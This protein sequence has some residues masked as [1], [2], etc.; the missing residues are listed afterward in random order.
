MRH[1]TTF[2]L[3]S[4]FII[5]MF[6]TQPLKAQSGGQFDRDI[7]IAE[8]I[9]EELFGEE[10]SARPFVSRSV[11]DVSG[12]YI[13]GYGIH[14]T[15]GSGSSAAFVGIVRPG[16]ININVN[17]ESDS[18][19]ESGSNQAKKREV[20]E[21]RFL[22]YLK[23]YAPLFDELPDDEV[24]RLTY[25]R[26]SNV[27]A[28][29]TIRAGESASRTDRVN[30]TAWATAEDIRAYDTNSISVREFESRVEIVDLSD[31]ET[32]RDQTVFASILQTSLEDVSDTLRIRRSP[33]PEYL[34]GLGL[35]FTI[36]ANL[37]S[38]WFGF[39][40][41]QIE[42]FRIHTDS[43]SVEISNMLEEIDFR[44]V[45]RIAERMDSI[46]GLRSTDID[47]TELRR[48][49]E[50]ARNRIVERQRE[51]LT[52]DDVNR[53]LDQFHNALT[54]T[55]QDYGPTLRSLESD[56]MLLITINWSGRHSALPARTELRIQKSDI[57]DGDEP[58][59]QVVERR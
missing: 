50:D 28:A 30:L 46:T 21:E 12:Q 57:M 3:I 8:G 27:P 24:V 35:S 36:H 19:S 52:D 14:F 44:E 7:R 10:E 58:T 39:G 45:E 40:D 5:T 55:I 54:E 41:I 20:V 33:L 1:L 53:L 13:P 9:I 56:E 34:P 17:E 18:D 51:S 6:F 42:G 16:E 23:N 15:I 22:E 29:L 31:R 25:G 47:A 32:E 59:L 2:T 37:R 48:S 43:L 49:A 4:I 38:G 26:Q 11:R